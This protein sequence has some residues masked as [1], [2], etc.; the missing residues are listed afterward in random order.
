MEDKN[1]N[2][3]EDNRRGPM[4]D[5]KLYV[6]REWSSPFSRGIYSGNPTKKQKKFVVIFIFIAL[7]IVVL[8]F[9]YNK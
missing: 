5:F 3:T 1:I 4:E 7:V 9:I 6:G 2:K 8:G